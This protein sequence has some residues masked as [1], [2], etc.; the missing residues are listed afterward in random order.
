MLCYSHQKSLYSKYFRKETPICHTY[1]GISPLHLTHPWVA[2]GNN[3]GS[4]DICTR[5][6]QTTKN[7]WPFG[8]QTDTL[9]TELLRVH[10]TNCFH[11]CSCPNGLNRQNPDLR[12]D[13]QIM[14]K[15]VIKACDGKSESKPSS[16]CFVLQSYT[17]P[18]IIPRF[19]EVLCIPSA[20]SHEEKKNIL[21]P[22]SSDCNFI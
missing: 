11:L 15:C 21:F 1:S 22:D 2:G 7:Q 18:G 20:R 9:T 14:G 8:Y 5:V 6:N 16:D 13:I 3:Q 4:F 17:H 19:F 12:P 10:A